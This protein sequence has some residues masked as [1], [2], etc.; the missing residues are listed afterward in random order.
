MKRIICLIIL[1]LILFAILLLEFNPV[2][3]SCGDNA[4]YMNMAKAIYTGKGLVQ[5]H[6]PDT[7]QDYHIAP[8]YP[9]ILALIGHFANNIK[10]VMVYKLFSMVCVWLFLLVFA[11]ILNRFLKMRWPEVIIITISLA[12]L[13]VIAMISSAVLTEG[14]FLLF[15]GISLHFLFNYQEMDKNRYL[16]L[17][18]IFCAASVMIRI[19]GFPIIGIFFLILLIDSDFRGAFKYLGT[20]I[21]ILL[22]LIYR[23]LFRGELVYWKQ[24]GVEN[25]SSGQILERVSLNANAYLNSIIPQNICP[26]IV[27]FETSCKCFSIAILALFVLSIFFLKERKKH[28]AFYLIPLFFA[29]V[30]LLF[31]HTS[32]RY[33]VVLVPFIIP[34]AMLSISRIINL[35]FSRRNASV[36]VYISLLFMALTVP[37]T[38]E[39]VV[40]AEKYRN[41]L[42]KQD[43]KIDAVIPVNENFEAFFDALNWIKNNTPNETVLISSDLRIAYLISDKSGVYIGHQWG[44]NLW[45]KALKYK[46]TY[47]ILDKTSIYIFDKMEYSYSLHPECLEI[48]YI[49]NPP[50]AIVFKIDSTCLRNKLEGANSSALPPEI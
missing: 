8:I 31:H 33:F 46:A 15:M 39:N 28:L 16:Y 29:P 47:M 34:L 10:A 44:D 20:S 21:L 43:Y 35:I 24:T 12:G 13:P 2:F 22:P 4:V 48:S 26:S 1:G 41:E 40:Y 23:V 11:N 42:S 9:A 18:A 5:L 7:P 25:F 27:Q 49:A 19:A 32:I 36:I 38:I 3:N 45:K 14:P 6:L 50:K 17:S 37:A 30:Y